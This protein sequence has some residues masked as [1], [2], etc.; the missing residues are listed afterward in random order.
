MRMPTHARTEKEKTR[1]AANASHRR[2]ISTFPMNVVG[3]RF[4]PFG[5]LVEPSLTE[6]ASS[7]ARA[8]LKSVVQW[9]LERTADQ[10][11]PHPRFATRMAAGAVRRW[12]AT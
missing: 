12:R 4:G 8:A 10:V 7:P 6:I 3:H 5:G 2:F 11:V 1:T 9:V